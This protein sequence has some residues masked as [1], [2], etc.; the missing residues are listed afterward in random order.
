MKYTTIEN[1]MEF[2][3]YLEEKSGF[4]S[5]ED[6]VSR[7]LKDF[8]SFIATS[9]KKCKNTIIQINEPVGSLAWYEDGPEWNVPLSFDDNLRM[10]ACFKFKLSLD[11][12]HSRL[13][14]GPVTVKIIK[15]LKEEFGSD[16][17]GYRPILSKFV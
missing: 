12:V 2:I 11:S 1:S 13:A 7:Y 9:H 10:M 16:G 3:K 17:V 4:K 5:H 15:V 6:R 8:G 14:S